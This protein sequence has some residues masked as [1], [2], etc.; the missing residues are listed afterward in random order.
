MLPGFSRVRKYHNKHM[1]M[2]T[3]VFKLYFLAFSQSFSWMQLLHLITKT[4]N[5]V[6]EVHGK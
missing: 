6:E 1:G 4:A 2:Q 5:K 3:V